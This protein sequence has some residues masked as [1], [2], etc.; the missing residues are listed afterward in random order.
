MPNPGF[1]V[2]LRGGRTRFQEPT[3]LKRTNSGRGSVSE[4]I[5]DSNS[6]QNPKQKI[7]VKS[8]IQ[9]ILQGKTT[10]VPIEV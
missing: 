8:Q 3:P 9:Q 1:C 5:E 4:A 2:V 10:Q 6:S 7:A